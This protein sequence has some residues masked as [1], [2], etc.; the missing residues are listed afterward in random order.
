MNKM[1]FMI[2]ENRRRSVAKFLSAA[3]GTDRF[4]RA[5]ALMMREH[6]L[7][8]E[9]GATSLKPRG[10]PRL[11]RF[12]TP[13]PCLNKS[14]T[15]ERSDFQVI[16]SPAA[17]AQGPLLDLLRSFATLFPCPTRVPNNG[18]RTQRTRA[19]SFTARPTRNLAHPRPLPRTPLP[20]KNKK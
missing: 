7:E 13:E 9:N 3:N 16:S 17:I 6:D 14:I 18:K 11:P 19:R 4:S 2:C 8:A 15:A 12:R 10:V 20:T 1:P 5:A